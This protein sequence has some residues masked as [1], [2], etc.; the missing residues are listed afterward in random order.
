VKFSL[1]DA[2]AL[3][4]E[5]LIKVLSVLTLFGR[6]NVQ[7]TAILRQCGLTRRLWGASRKFGEHVG[8]IQR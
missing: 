7:N 3:T 5:I 8:A 4:R 1:I 6:N 2:Q